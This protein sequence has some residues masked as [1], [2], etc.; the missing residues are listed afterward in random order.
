MPPPVWAAELPL[1][2]LLIRVTWPS[3]QIPPPWS[4][5]T[6]PLIVLLTTLSSGSVAMT[7]L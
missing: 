5:A 1:T 4:P 6:L 3:H 7:G 2:V